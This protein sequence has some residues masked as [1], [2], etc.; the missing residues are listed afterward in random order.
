MVEIK[1]ELQYW[2]QRV[3]DEHRE[4]QERR[5]KLRD[6]LSSDTFE[7]VPTEQQHLLCKQCEVMDEYVLILEK[8]IAAFSAAKPEAGSYSETSSH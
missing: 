8:R 2:Q 5:N 4:L 7:S 6:F 1:K 3:V